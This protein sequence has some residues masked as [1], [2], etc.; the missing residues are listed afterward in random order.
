[1]KYRIKFLWMHN[2]GNSFFPHLSVFFK[3]EKYAK[4]EKSIKSDDSQPT[5]WPAHVSSLDFWPNFTVSS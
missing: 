5:V 4:V 2:I 1:M 3:V